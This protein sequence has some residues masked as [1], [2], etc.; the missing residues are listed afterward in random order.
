MKKHYLKYLQLAA[1]ILL[2]Q[3]CLMENPE[4]KM[5]KLANKYKNKEISNSQMLFG[6]GKIFRENPDNQ[7]IRYEYFQKMIISGY[8]SH[9]VHCYLDQ[10][11]KSLTVEDMEILLFA[12]QEGNHY[13]LA[14]K[15][16]G[17]FNGKYQAK[18]LEAAGINDS[19]LYY[20]NLVKKNPDAEAMQK[21]GKFFTRLN[22]SDIANIDLDKSIR[23]N[24]CNPG[25][26]FEKAL[27]LINN[28]KTK[29]VTEMLE[30]CNQNN[31]A[32]QLEWFPVIYN[33]AK[34]VESLKKSN[35]PKKEILFNQANLYIN[36]GFPEIALQKSKELLKADGNNNP[37]YLALQGFIYF[38]MNNKELAMHYVSE[39]ER[40]SGKKSKLS[41]MIAK[42][43]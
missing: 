23:L 31:E 14:E 13:H 22:A 28:E 12:L 7:V 42:M 33:L 10:P 16:T 34:E 1:C 21:R 37:D 20:N 40:I 5:Q 29:E 2:L 27:L 32:T 8:A 4:S 17:R 15:F 9:I 3:S 39:A 18:L 26:L 24:P 19:L 41:S 35:L 36:A 30:K 43:E 25:A 38:K 6:M 11:G